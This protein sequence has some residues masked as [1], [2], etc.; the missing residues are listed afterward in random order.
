MILS[1]KGVISKATSADTQ[2]FCVIMHH[3]LTS[4]NCTKQ[5]YDILSI[6]YIEVVAF[7]TKLMCKRGQEVK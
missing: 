7:E 4:C 5:L 2:H 3:I 1:N 6:H